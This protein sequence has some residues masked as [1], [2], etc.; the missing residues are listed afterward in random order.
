MDTRLLDS[1][2]TCRHKST[3]MTFLRAFRFGG[4]VL[5]AMMVFAPGY[6][7]ECVNIGEWNDLVSTVRPATGTLM[8]CKFDIDKTASSERLLLNKCLSISC[9]GA[10]GQIGKNQ[11][12]SYAARKKMELSTVERWLS[13]ILN[14][15]RN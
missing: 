5:L 2:H 10:V 13:P 7:S 4:S 12:E 11:V 8:L 9:F 6:A 14:Y 1:F 3:V 15:E